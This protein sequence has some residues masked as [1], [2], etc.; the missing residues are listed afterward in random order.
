LLFQILGVF[1]TQ[2]NGTGEYILKQSNMDALR[3]SNWFSEEPA[4]MN[5]AGRCAMILGIGQW[6]MRDCLHQ[7]HY[8]C[9]K[10]KGK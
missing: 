4:Y 1:S 2:I 5:Y 9:E 6:R 8:V 3:Y 7:L 10:Q